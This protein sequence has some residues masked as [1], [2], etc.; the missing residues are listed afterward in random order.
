MCSNSRGWVP[1]HPLSL[2]APTSELT[3]AVPFSVLRWPMQQNQ[4]STGQL[5]SLFSVSMGLCALS[6]LFTLVWPE[7]VTQTTKS[8]TDAVFGSVGGLFLISVS[9]FL[10]LCVWLAFSRYGKIRLGPED[11]KPE[12]STLSWL[13]MLFA[14]GMGT[15]LVVW[16]AAEPM[17]HMLKPPSGAVGTEETMRQ[18]FVITNYHWGIHA[19]AIYGIGALVLAYFSFVRGGVYLASTPIRLGFKGD[20]TR[21][22]GSGAD[23]LAIFSVTF[24]VAGSIAMGTLQVQ[25]GL[26]DFMGSTLDSTP[27]QITVL[28]VLFVAYM[29]SASTGLAKGIRILSNLNIA[30]AVLVIFFIFSVGPTERLMTRFVESVFDYAM[31]LGPLSIDLQPFGGSQEWVNGWTLIYFVWWIAWTPFVGTFIARISKGRTIREFIIGVLICPTLFSIFW[32]AVLGGV[33]A[34]MQMNGL[35]DF[36]P[37]LVED[38]T[39]IIYVVFSQLPASQFLGLAA[40]ILVFVFLITSVDSATFV[41]GMLSSEG[42]LEPSS[43]IKLVWGVVLGLLGAGFTFLGDIDVIKLMTISGA[44]PFLLVLLLQL[45]AFLRALPNHGVEPSFSGT[46]TAQRASDGLD[47]GHTDVVQPP[48]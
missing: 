27:T 40:T 46:T 19:W 15:G 7:Q 26:N 13:S 28:F 11:G 4:R 41:L 9:L 35:Q 6:G 8:F 29:A 23:L 33:A 16:G 30:F 22:V 32:F 47:G 1:L 42:S 10:V 31:A 3:V 36:G 38:M 45:V 25:S 20:W 48:D 2:Q 14:A 39:G 17:Y 12:F 21:W 37:T 34:D 18:A 5:F 24:G 43:R 44:V